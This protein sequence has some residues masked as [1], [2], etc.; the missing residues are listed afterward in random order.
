MIVRPFLDDAVI[1]I[2]DHIGAHPAVVP[3]KAA[4]FG[5]S[6]HGES[7]QGRQPGLEGVGHMRVPIARNVVTPEV[8]AALPTVE[9][10]A[11]EGTPKILLG[12]RVGN[13]L[14]KEA[15]EEILGC[16][17]AVFIRFI[18]ARPECRRRRID[19]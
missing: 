6:S 15:A 18:P 19:L 5:G 1:L 2:G 9:M 17:L 16:R 10:K 8:G 4:G 12:A 3:E 11:D 7:E 14:L 13:D